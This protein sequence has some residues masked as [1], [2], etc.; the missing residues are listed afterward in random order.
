MK[1][2]DWQELATTSHYQTAVA[3]RNALREG[4]ADDASAGLEEL[5]DA[6]SRADA[7]ALRSHLVRLIQHTIKWQVQPQL[8]SQSWVA[9]IAIQR[10]EITDLRE[11][12]P[13]FTEAYIR[14]RLWDRCVQLAVKE[15][16]R[17]LNQAIP[18]PPVLN[19]NDVFETDYQ[20]SPRSQQ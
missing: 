11:E 14:E 15:A 1:T 20:I 8:R 3:I 13:R 7:R 5:I 17:D 18:N 19:W 4:N 2:E 10:Q 6:L 9:T 16:E 12:N